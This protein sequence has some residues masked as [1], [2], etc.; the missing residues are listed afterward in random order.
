[1]IYVGLKGRMANQMFLIA[2][3]HALSLSNKTQ[4]VCSNS[5]QGITPSPLETK[6]HRATIFKNIPFVKNIKPSSLHTDRSDF[7]FSPIRYLPEMCLSGYYQSEKYFSSHTKEIKSLFETPDSID[8]IIKKKFSG[9]VAKNNTCSVHVRRGDYIKYN[10]YHNNLSKKY[11]NRCFEQVGLDS[12]F[13]FFSDDVAW[14]K[15][16]FSDV[17]A[18]FVETGFDVL[19]FYLMSKMKNNI[20]ANSSFSWWAAWLNE[21]CDKRV[22]APKNWFGPKN[23]NLSTIDLIPNSWE[24]VDA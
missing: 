9:L 22:I 19:D 11:Y 5:I 21:N 10:D 8:N 13:V 7:K 6:K 3:A 2:A 20:I 16:T 14:C 1:M 4:Y 23:Q 12:H 15:Q 17:D 24:I 18:T